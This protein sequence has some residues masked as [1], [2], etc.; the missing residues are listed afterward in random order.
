METDD[1]SAA[2]NER[3]KIK[4]E[5]VPKPAAS[6]AAGYFFIAVTPVLLKQDVFG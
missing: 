1:R 4:G 5:V 6:Y 3:S 2:G